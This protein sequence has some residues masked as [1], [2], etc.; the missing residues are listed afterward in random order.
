MSCL[1]SDFLL[2][3]DLALTKNELITGNRVIDD[4]ILK[5][6]V[7]TLS[8]LVKEFFIPLFFSLQLYSR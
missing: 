1:S 2:T 7:A 6:Q 4:R 5:T 3:R 8:T